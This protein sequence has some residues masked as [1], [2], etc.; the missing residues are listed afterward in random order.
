MYREIV[1]DLMKWRNSDK[2]K[3]LVITGMRQCGKTY[4]MQKFGKEAFESVV[5]INLEKNELA[6]SIFEYDYD[7]HRIVNELSGFSEDGKII[8]GKSLLIIDEIQAC[9]RAITALK[10]F[11]EDMRE[12]HVMCAGS[13]LGVALKHENISFPVG[14]INRLQMYPMSFKEYLIA[15][16]E[17]NIVKILNDYAKDRPLADSLMGRMEKLLKNYLLV[18]GMPE[19]VASWCENR[20]FEEVAE[21]QDNILEDYSSDFSKHAPIADVPK[22][23]WIWES[24]PK[25]LAKENNKFVFSQVKSGKRAHELENALQ[26]LVDSGLV[27]RCELAVNPE[28]PLSFSADGSY[29]KIYMADVGLLCRRTGLSYKALLAENGVFSSFKGALTENYV[30]NEL[31]YLDKK[32]YFWRSG[33]TAEVDFL[34]EDDENVIPVEVKSADNTR[35]KSYRLFCNRHKPSVGYKF[36]LKNTGVNMTEQT[37]TYNIPLYMIWKLH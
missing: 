33:N 24:V 17:E 1:K 3:P 23:H 29:F 37:E 8:P 18:G 26:W 22:L 7:V 14:K 5:Y 12:L 31:I 34:I 2:R 15:C 30:H 10:Y 25:Q 9:P 35:A 36:S 11:C 32:P 13:L 28:I 21:I 6:A 20:S 16:D 4:V 19:A 27:Y